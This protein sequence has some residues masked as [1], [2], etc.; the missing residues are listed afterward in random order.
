[1]CMAAI[2]WAKIPRVVFGTSIPTLREL[3][4]WQM[5]LRAA[6]TASYAAGRPCEIVG[7]VLEAD[8]DALFRTAG[9]SR[10]G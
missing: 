2:L 7:G 1:M 4:W 5:S 9:K 3:D 8:C 10:L 6:H